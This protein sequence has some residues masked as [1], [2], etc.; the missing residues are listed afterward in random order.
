M[1]ASTIALSQFDTATVYEGFKH[2]GIAQSAINSGECVVVHNVKAHAGYDSR[3]DALASIQ[4][5]NCL[6]APIVFGD[7]KANSRCVGVLFATN[8]TQGGFLGP[9]APLQPYSHI[10]LFCIFSNH[11]AFH[12]QAPMS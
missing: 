12:E 9:W 6:A 7:S 3:L 10:D 1:H 5:S 4:G 2:N 8:K 11:D